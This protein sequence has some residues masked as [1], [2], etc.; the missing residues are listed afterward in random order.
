MHARI[1]DSINIPLFSD[2]ERKIVGT[3]FK[4]VSREEAIKIGLDYFGP[5]MKT[6]VEQIEAMPEI[7]SKK[8]VVHCWRGGMRSEAI[9]WLLDLYGFEVYQLT[10]GYKAFRLWAIS[11]FDQQHNFKVLGGYTGSGKTEILHILTKTS[12]VVDLEALANHKGS[13]LGRLETPQPSQE[14]FENLL[15]IALSQF[16]EK[17][18]IWIE[19]ESQRIGN[20]IIPNAVYD[21]MQAAP[22]LFLEIPKE[23]RLSF[24]LK[25]YGKLE[26]ENIVNSI[27]RI[28]KKL[29]GLAM[30]TA[31]R[32]LEEDRLI[33]CF[34]VLLDYYDKLYKKGFLNRKNAITKTF[35]H[36]KFTEIALQIKNEI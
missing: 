3:T 8:I 14:M 15:G 9:T 18:P 28:Q 21:T 6:I 7:R 19:D 13:A 32:A 26:K 31:L 12:P 30:Q 24:I 1:P 4:Q 35:D 33:D 20:L 5:K 23:L 2:E 22:L 25:E 29:G 17:E 27:I 36:L 34:E 16:S 10:G 11:F